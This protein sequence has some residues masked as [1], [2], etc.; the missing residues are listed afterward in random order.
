MR[1]SPLTRPFVPCT[2]KSVTR[3]PTCPLICI[4]DS[5]RTELRVTAPLLS[6]NM[7]RS[8][9]RL[10]WMSR[11]VRFCR[12][13]TIARGVASKRTSSCQRR[14]T[15]SICCRG[16]RVIAPLLSAIETC[17]MRAAS[18]YIRPTMYPRVAAGPPA[19]IYALAKW[20]SERHG[21]RASTLQ[22][23]LI[24]LSLVV[25]IIIY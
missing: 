18:S 2:R 19:S 3:P 6:E 14:R 11:T 8:C 13:A 15:A 4:A 5:R 1:K 23:G 9:R 24:C 12:P 7:P 17:R 25:R 22:Q 10:L 21:K 20:A 16:S